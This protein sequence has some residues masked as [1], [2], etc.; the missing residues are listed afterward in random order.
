MK[1][2]SHIHKIVP[3]PVLSLRLHTR[4]SWQA[5]DGSTVDVGARVED[6]LDG[7]A[8][9]PPD[10]QQYPLGDGRGGILV[11]KRWRGGHPRPQ[12]IRHIGGYGTRESFVRA[13]AEADENSDT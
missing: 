12:H 13:L 7:K 10:Q 1:Q 6:V 3:S 4:F 8:V 11:R 5:A 2:S 9:C